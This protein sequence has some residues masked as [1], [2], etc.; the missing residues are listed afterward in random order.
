MRATRLH[1]KEAKDN[2][3][4]EEKS[5]S[6]LGDQTKPE[7]SSS[8][9]A[10]GITSS[11]CFKSVQHKLLPEP[12]TLKGESL[13]SGKMHDFI[14]SGTHKDTHSL[15]LIFVTSASSF[16]SVMLSCLQNLL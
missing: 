15:L 5:C 16:L 6:H 8:H 14:Y 12:T 7:D 11:E 2:T 1:S 3:N 9:K 10:V 13:L 4:P